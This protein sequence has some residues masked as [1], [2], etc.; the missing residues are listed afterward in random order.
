MIGP[1][2]DI[3]SFEASCSALGAAEADLFRWVSEG[4][5]RAYRMD[6][7]V[8]FHETDVEDLIER[9]RAA[10]AKPFVS[11]EEAVGISG[12]PAEDL[13]RRMV[14][15]SVTAYRSDREIFFRKDEMLRLRL[16][17]GASGGDGAIAGPKKRP[18]GGP[19]LNLDEAAGR[20]GL[21]RWELALLV[22]AGELP[23]IRP[24]G[25]MVFRRSEV[26]AFRAARDKERSSPAPSVPASEIQKL[27]AAVGFRSGDGGAS[28]PEAIRR[29]VREIAKQHGV[30]AETLEDLA[31][32]LS[33][34]IAALG[35]GD[36]G[37]SGRR[38]GRKP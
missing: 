33:A 15:G 8:K 24:C 5:L 23:T 11:F 36:G 1:Q 25:Q 4:R 29:R 37:K 26:G 12:H 21:S 18:P 14:E 34:L 30:A 28:D 10:R 22:D 35:D 20:T 6:P 38:E 7:D 32:G 19:T 2:D 9:R 16:S 3:L 17:N 27:S 31:A 13:M